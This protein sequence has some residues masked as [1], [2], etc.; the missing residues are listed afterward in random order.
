[1]QVDAQADYLE[2]LR[3]QLIVPESAAVLVAALSPDSG[4]LLDQLLNILRDSGKTRAL[5][6][7]SAEHFSSSEALEKFIGDV[8]KQIEQQVAQ[9][10][11]VQHAKTWGGGL[12]EV[13]PHSLKL[14]LKEQALPKVASQFELELEGLSYLE[15]LLN[16]LQHE[17]EKGSNSKRVILVPNSS[18]SFIQ[19]LEEIK[20]C[21]SSKLLSENTW[22]VIPAY[23]E[24]KRLAGVLRALR[25]LTPNLVVVDD[26]SGD[27][28]L[29]VALQFTPHVLRHP[30][31]LGAGAATQTGTDYALKNGAEFLVHFDADGQMLIRD[32]PAMLEPLEAGRCDVVFG[33]RYLSGEIYVPLIKNLFIHRPAIILNWILT[34]I[35][36]TDAHCGFRAFSK[37]GAQL[38]KL[39]LD[40]FAHATELMELV[41]MHRLNYQEVPVLIRYDH[42][43][44]TGRAGLKILKDLL[45]SKLLKVS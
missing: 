4:Q 42:Y 39:T 3:K 32:I 40:R 41:N 12:S 37:K 10:Q 11:I 38:C 24:E 28:T 31:N 8:T 1:M 25:K 44:Q 2:V 22:I 9:V 21:P 34:G 45:F 33:S 7:I 19:K 6:T 26:C 23:N 17:I 30:I 14:A 16:C 13:R 15:D 43:G 36:L 18:K 20:A 5:L 27:K 35:L 29:S